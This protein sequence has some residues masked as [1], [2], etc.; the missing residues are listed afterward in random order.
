MGPPDQ[1]PRRRRAP[2]GPRR[3]ARRPPRPPSP[4]ARAPPLRAGR[5]RRRDRRRGRAGGRRPGRR[6]AR[7]RGDCN[8]RGVRGARPRAEQ[9]TPR[10]TRATE[11][12]R[13]RDSLDLAART[14]RQVEDLLGRRRQ[15]SIERRITIEGDLLQGRRG[16][17]RGGGHG[18]RRH[19]QARRRRSRRE[20]SASPSPTRRPPRFASARARTPRSRPACG[21]PPR[22]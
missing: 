18:A 22:K 4:R 10:P 13:A 20:R 1:P 2:V 21:R 5:A 8:P 7:A 9:P 15:D 16:A 17:L 12:S 3:R 6:R 19:R 14:A 11:V